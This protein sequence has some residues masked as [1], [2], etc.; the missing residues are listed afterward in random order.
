MKTKAILWGLA[1]VTLLTTASF[2]IRKGTK[3]NGP[4]TSSSISGIIFDKN[5][6]ES[7][8]GVTVQLSSTGR[9]IYSDAKG[10]FNLEDI[11]PGTYKVKVNCISYKEQEI[12]VT[13]KKS[14][15]EKLKIQLNPIEP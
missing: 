3:T 4:S 14:Q 12:T 15:T 11:A 10:E 5:S 9:K 8:T 1:L 13:I 7:L 6:N 2:A